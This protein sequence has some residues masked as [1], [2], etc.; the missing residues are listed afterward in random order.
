MYESDVR[1]SLH[2]VHNI[3]SKYEFMW[4]KVDDSNVRKKLRALRMRIGH[5]ARADCVTAAF[6]DRVSA[7]V[8]DNLAL[9]MNATSLIRA[10]DEDDADDVAK[11]RFTIHNV[12]DNILESLAEL[13]KGLENPTPPNC[14][15][16]AAIKCLREKEVDITSEFVGD[17]RA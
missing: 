1:D 11:D 14:I 2:Q 10:P 6:V 8:V 15:V 7:F 4:E 5:V 12:C 3:F 16:D 17:V 13:R 9:V